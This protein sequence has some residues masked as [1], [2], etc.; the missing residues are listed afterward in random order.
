[1]FGSLWQK[2]AIQLE[3]Q[4]MSEKDSNAKMSE[5]ESTADE[6][7]ELTEDAR[8]LG[9]RQE[10]LV[11]I[12]VA[13]KSTG[14][15]DALKMADVDANKQRYEP[16]GAAGQWVYKFDRLRAHDSPA[17]SLPEREGQ[18][19][20]DALADEMFVAAV[21]TKEL[22]CAENDDATFLIFSDG[23]G[24]DWYFN[25]DGEYMAYT[26]E[27]TAGIKACRFRREDEEEG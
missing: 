12:G 27:R 14:A 7:K 22:D 23:T 3:E 16:Y 24:M 11:R 2:W 20:W 26:A 5:P 15:G 21:E 10:G 8:D 13:I 19:M 17:H 6:N 4:A 25:S 1:V 18:A 9:P